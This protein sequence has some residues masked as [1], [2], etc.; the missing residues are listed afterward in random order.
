[1]EALYERVVAL[2]TSVSEGTRDHTGRLT[3]LS[4]GVPSDIDAMGLARMLTSALADAGIEFVDLELVEDA[5]LCVRE[6]RFE[7]WGEG[8]AE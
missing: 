2:A 1:M 7:G 3:A 6:A 8:P 5:D 4:V